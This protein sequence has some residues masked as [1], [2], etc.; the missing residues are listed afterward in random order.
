MSLLALLLEYFIWLL[1]AFCLQICPPNHL[2]AFTAAFG[3][4]FRRDSLG[5]SLSARLENCLYSV[6]TR[7]NVGTGAKSL[8]HQ[9]LC[10]S[11]CRTEP[12][13]VN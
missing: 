8:R 3:D 6:G 7:A 2:H 1:P 9:S 5:C 4:I 11:S 12:P 13:K 10:G